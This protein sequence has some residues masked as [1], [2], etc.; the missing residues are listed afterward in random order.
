MMGGRGRERGGKGRQVLSATA[1]PFPFLSEAQEGLEVEEMPFFFIPPCF[2][3]IGV[4][5]CCP[6]P[7]PTHCSTV[8]QSNGDG[9]DTGGD[10]PVIDGAFGCVAAKGKKGGSTGKGDT[11]SH[12]VEREG[13]N[14]VVGLAK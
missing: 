1:S 12:R 14:R 8:P 13:K 5:A 10:F 11:H 6:L 4:M 3:W 2:P 9:G 7:P